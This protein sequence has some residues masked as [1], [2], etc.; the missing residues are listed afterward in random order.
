MKVWMPLCAG[1]EYAGSAS[2]DEENESTSE[3]EEED[4]D[5]QE[6]DL[7]D[8][9]NN[10]L[11]PEQEASQ[12]QHNSSRTDPSQAS[13]VSH[14]IDLTTGEHIQPVEI[15]QFKPSPTRSRRK[16]KGILTNSNRPNN[17][18]R[19]YIYHDES[20]SVSSET[21]VTETD[22]AGQTKGSESLKPIEIRQFKPSP[23]RKVRFND[24]HQGKS[25]PEHNYIYH[26]ESFSVSSETETDLNS[27]VNSLSG[28]RHSSRGHHHHSH[29]RFSHHHSHEHREHDRHLLDISYEYD[30]DSYHSSDTSC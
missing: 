22:L 25:R 23:S 30:E 19:D 2:T 28:H 6:E 21:E 18:N 17:Y 4:D 5:D 8:W 9:V 12:N 1:K 7:I 26:D 16:V 15:R 29:D 3:E 13:R 10:P 11:L 14:D 27:S 20:F 24:R